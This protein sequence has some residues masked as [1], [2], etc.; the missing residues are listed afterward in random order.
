MFGDISPAG[1]RPAW[2]A[3]DRFIN[4]YYDL[5]KRRSA[6]QPASA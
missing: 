6:E 4:M 5:L 2:L 1:E 3:E